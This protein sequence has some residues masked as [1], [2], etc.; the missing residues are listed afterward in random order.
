M[1][2][3]AR[4]AHPEVSVRRLCELHDISRSWFYEQQGREEQDADQALCQA[5]YLTG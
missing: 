3:D 1:I 4:V 2:Q 5:Q